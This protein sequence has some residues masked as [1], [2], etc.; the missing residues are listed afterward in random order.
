MKSCLWCANPCERY[1]K[2]IAVQSNKLLSSEQ[3]E[4]RTTTALECIDYKER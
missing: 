1:F 4:L 3:I 2:E